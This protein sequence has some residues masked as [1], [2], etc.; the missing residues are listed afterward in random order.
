MKNYQKASI[1]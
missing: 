1:L